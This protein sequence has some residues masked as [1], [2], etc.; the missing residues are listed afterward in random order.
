MSWINQLFDWNNQ[1]TDPSES[2]KTNGFKGG[3]RPPASVFNAFWYK[4][5]KAIKEL[6][7]NVEKGANKTTVDSALSSTSTNPVQN[8][9]IN[10]ALSGKA[11][12]SHTHDDRYYT[13]SEI[14]TKL[15]G[16][17]DSSHTHSTATTSANGFMSSS[18]KAKLDGIAAGAN[19]ITV[20]SS[21]SSTSTNPVQNKVIN[22]AL[23]GKADSSHTHSDYLPKSGGTMTGALTLKG[24]PTADL[25][26]ATKKYVDDTAPLIIN[27]QDLSSETIIKE[28]I[29]NISSSAHKRKVFMYDSEYRIFNL[30]YSSVTIATFSN[31][32]SGIICTVNLDYNTGSISTDE[33]DTTA[34][35]R[36]VTLSSTGWTASGDVYTQTATVS[37]VSATETEQEIH[38]TPA[39]A[40]MTAYMESGVYASAQAANQI[41]F[42]A[43]KVPT[44][45]LTVYALIKT[46]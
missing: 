1:G 4:V 2:L 34:T 18:D 33:V 44:A 17:A 3:M 16:K 19:T 13:E 14:D 24:A 29:T 45:N 26:A 21:L 23:S 20:D 12:S 36:T 40:S 37:G 25:Q 31:V 15:S 41:T 42:T 43:S 6:Q 32:D 39:T 11:N 5:I 10:T 9:V 46:L 35:R 30:V 7:D 22:T 28:T 8:K 27:M 38:V